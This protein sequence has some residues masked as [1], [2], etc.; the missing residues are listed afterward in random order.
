[1]A[2]S[3]SPTGVRRTA[4]LVGLAVAGLIALL[5]FGSD[6]RLDPKNAV[7]G[8]RVPD[9]AGPT[10]AG[11][12]YDIDSARGKWVVVNF[13]ATWCPGCINEHPELLAFHDWAT[14]TGSAEVVAVVFND[15]PESVAAFFEANGGD[16]PVLDEP[17]IPIEFQV[18]QIPETFV[19]AP[20][21]QVIRHIQ[22]EVTADELI[23]T[24]EGR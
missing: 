19:V 13:F 5:A 24:I 6:D 11:D 1:M 3:A 15:P 23:A 14:E 18:A 10:L 4:L 21:G 20:S 8:A 12:S 2:R 17:S 7:L 16:W 22:G 9:V